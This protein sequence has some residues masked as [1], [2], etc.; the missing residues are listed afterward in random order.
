MRLIITVTRAAALE[1]TYTTVHIAMAALRRGH[2]VRFV[3][4][5]DFEV[6]A[7]G[8]VI[9]RAHAFDEPVE[10]REALV[11][12]LCERQAARRYIE[13][14]RQD[15]L[16]LRVNPLDGAVLAF[17][18]LAQRAGVVVHNDPSTLMLTGH[19]GYLATLADV[20][21]PRTL[22]TRSRATTLLFASEL[23]TGII[24]KPARSSGG[25]AVSY[26][27]SPRQKRKIEE[28]FDLA[29][30]HGDGYVVLQE[31]LPEAQDGEKRLVWLDGELLGGYL[32]VRAPGEFR[33]NLSQGSTPSP[34]AIGPQDEALARAVTPYLQRDGVWLAGLDVIGGRIVE[35]N[36]LNPG[37]VHFGDLLGG[38]R[39]AEYIVARLEA[40]HDARNPDASPDPVPTPASRPYR[41][42][43]SKSA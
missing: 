29:R 28:A 19:K 6:D 35:V 4:P 22:V 12:Q 1:T 39:M 30:L 5:W 13:L 7:L 17:A 3:E 26:V 2:K 41:F 32:R 38:T 16:L 31:Y 9:A 11:R 34:C 33:H 25:R 42:H 15:T 18:Q 14:S 37:G 27:P 10:D 36:T 21:R 23:R 8:R 43:E 40:E 24:V 20:P